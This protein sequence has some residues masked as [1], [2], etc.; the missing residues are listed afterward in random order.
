MEDCNFSKEKFT[1]KVLLK[2]EGKV[3]NKQNTKKKKK[4]KQNLK[5]QLQLLPITGTPQGRQRNS[6]LCQTIGYEQ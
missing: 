3:N 4:G 2:I 5:K 6:K 1:R